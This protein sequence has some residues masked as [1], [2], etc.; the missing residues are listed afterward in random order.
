MASQIWKQRNLW[1][2]HILRGPRKI[3]FSA[4]CKTCWCQRI[5][6]ISDEGLKWNIAS[7]LGYRFSVGTGGSV[8][9]Y[10][11]VATWVTPWSEGRTWRQVCLA[12]PVAE[13]VLYIISRRRRSSTNTIAMFTL[14]HHRWSALRVASSWSRLPW[15]ARTLWRYFVCSWRT[16]RGNWSR[17]WKLFVTCSRPSSVW[18][19][20][21][22]A[23]G[24]SSQGTLGGPCQSQGGSQWSDLHHQALPGFT[25][26][27]ARG[28]HVL[29]H[30]KWRRTVF[31]FIGIKFP[32][33]IRFMKK[34]YLDL[35]YK[36]ASSLG[37]IKISALT[38]WL[39]KYQILPDVVTLNYNL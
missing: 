18:G 21:V 2:T 23:Q 28:C 4:F 22:S 12:L 9:G 3:R 17:S 39:I 8:I 32:K 38:C 7:L 36:M 34:K 10:R 29:A 16:H 30:F 5:W 24:A 13:N 20:E 25:W 26:S 11:Q 31:N 19:K 33:R 35:D 14:R 6:R 37:N 15:H 27:V 1:L